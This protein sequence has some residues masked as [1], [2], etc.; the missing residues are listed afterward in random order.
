MTRAMNFALDNDTVTV[1]AVV[2][3]NEKCQKAGNEE[4]DD[5][6]VFLLVK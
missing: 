4:E 3:V 5:V 1:V 2:A 6:P